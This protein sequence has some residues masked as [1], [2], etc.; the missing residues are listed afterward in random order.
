MFFLEKCKH[1][2]L[3]T[4][5]Y[6]KNQKKRKNIS[7]PYYKNAMYILQFC[8]S[9]KKRD[10]PHH[11][12]MAHLNFILLCKKPYAGLFFHRF[13][14]VFSYTAEWAYP[15]FRNIFK[16]CSRFNS[17]IWV[18]CC[19]V[20]DPSAYYASVLHNCIL[21]LMVNILFSHPQM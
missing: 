6:E 3:Q 21:F 11:T 9:H 1:L 16:T 18:T 14:I 7:Q 5:K 8:P 15:I 19:G 13:E 2:I 12:D 20:V 17:S 4:A 10:V